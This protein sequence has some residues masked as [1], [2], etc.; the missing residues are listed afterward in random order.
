MGSDAGTNSTLTHAPAEIPRSIFGALFR[1]RG[2]GA[3][4]DQGVVSLGNFLTNIFLARYWRGEPETY[5]IYMLCMMVVLFLNNLHS[6]LVTYPLTVNGAVGGM[7]SFRRITGHALT[8]TAMLMPVLGLGLV[9]VTGL[10]H[11]LLLLPYL[12]VA[13]VMW[14]V[15]ETLRRAM[16]SRLWHLKAL[17]GDALS[18][19]GQAA[20]VLVL[21]LNGRLT[22][23]T[24]F[25]AVGATSCMA[26][27]LQAIQL[28]ARPAGLQE[29]RPAAKASWRLG[30]WPLLTQLINIGLLYLTPWVLAGTWGNT[31]VANFAAVATVLNLTNPVVVGICGLIIPAVAAAKAADGPQAGMRVAVRY[32]LFGLMMLVPYYILLLA[33]PGWALR[34]FFGQSV[35]V[36]L[37]TE[38]RLFV[39]GYGIYFISHICN[40]ALN[41]LE[42]ARDTSV[43]MLI[44]AGANVAFCMPLTIQFGLKGAVWGGL[45]PIVMQAAVLVILLKRTTRTRRGLVAAP[46]KART[47]R[48]MPMMPAVESQPAVGAVSGH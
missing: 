13:M 1:S 24:A 23:E 4:G 8:L 29:I 18:Y 5:G 30:R 39:V 27:V 9:A 38:L 40:A 33:F 2:I 11:R 10:E 31:E 46:M 17:P 45:L 47:D 41:G 19:L 7:E 15:Q 28:G 3:L 32:G 25:L 6:S 21:G 36:T 26:A 42:R 37:T 34:M 14:Q 44:G 20:V 48:A 12:A 35:Y 43:A 22:L 16:L